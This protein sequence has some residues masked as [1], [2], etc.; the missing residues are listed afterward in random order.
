MK[1]EIR[2]LLL[3]RFYFFRQNGEKPSKQRRR[4]AMASGR[5]NMK[6]SSMRILYNAKKQEEIQ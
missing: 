4:A 6:Y 2:P 3:K 1:H 5:L